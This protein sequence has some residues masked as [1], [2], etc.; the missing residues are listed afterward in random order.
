MSKI[1]T[2]T[3]LTEALYEQL[4]KEAYETKTSQAEIIEKALKAYLEQ[5]SQKSR[6]LIPGFAYLKYPIILSLMLHPKLSSNNSRNNNKYRHIDRV[7]VSQPCN[8]K[9][10]SH[11]G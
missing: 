11:I 6:G 4:R 3:Y 2:T 7:Q 1:R 8:Y 5:K 10:T 9:Q